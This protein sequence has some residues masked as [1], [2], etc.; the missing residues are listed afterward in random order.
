VVGMLRTGHDDP[1]FRACRA[2]I[3]SVIE[4]L[5]HAKGRTKEV[6]LG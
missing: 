1:A 5:R 3:D 2:S 4:A 6:P